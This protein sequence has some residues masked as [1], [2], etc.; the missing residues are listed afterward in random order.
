M[1]AGLRSRWTMPCLVRRFEG[2]GDLPREDY[3]FTERYRAS[4]DTLGQSRAFHQL[5]H[6]A[7]RRLR[8]RQ[9]HGDIGMVQRRQHLR[10]ALETAPYGRGRPQSWKA[11]P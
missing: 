1:L 4:R 9:N 5:H 3:C 10:F 11:G 2:I 8:S 7:A 6:Q